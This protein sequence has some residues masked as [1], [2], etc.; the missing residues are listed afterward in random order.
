MIGIGDQFSI[1][2]GEMLRKQPV[3]AQAVKFG[4]FLGYF[5]MPV[6]EFVGADAVVS[7]ERSGATVEL[8]AVGLESGATLAC[9]V[10]NSVRL[11][12]VVCGEPVVVCVSEAG[13]PVRRV[14]FVFRSVN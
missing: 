11:S 14:R 9:Q 7:F 8:G 12:G 3:R 13:Q 1:M 4:G 10:G 2:P 5:K 6:L